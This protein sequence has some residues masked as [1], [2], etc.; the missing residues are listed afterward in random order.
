M[1]KREGS[2]VEEGRRQIEDDDDSR[3]LASSRHA[4]GTRSPLFFF[5][6]T[7]LKP[8]VDLQSAE[9][10]RRRDPTKA[11]PRARARRINMAPSKESQHQHRLVGRFSFCL[12]LSLFSPPS[13]IYQSNQLTDLL[14]VVVCDGGR[15]LETRI[16]NS[17]RE[18]EFKRGKV[19]ERAMKKR[20]KTAAV[21]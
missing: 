14:I 18:Q 3:L 7:R 21:L 10:K 6:K 15:H 16:P 8:A 12:S 11:R 9:R 20:K 4:G 5:E 17:E 1:R 2:R 13:L 19:G